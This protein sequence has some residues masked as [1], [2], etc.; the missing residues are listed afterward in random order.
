MSDGYETMS[1]GSVTFH[2]YRQDQPKAAIL[3]AP[4]MGAPQRYYR[5]F[6]DFLNTSGYAVISFDYLGIGES[7]TADITQITIKDWLQNVED[8]MD[9]VMK[10]YPSTTYYYICHSL[11]G[12]LFGLTKKAQNFKKMV[13]ITSQNGY[14]RY[15][16]NKWRYLIVWYVLFP[17]LTRVYGYFP[18][19]KVGL[20][21]DLPPNIALNWKKWCTSKDYFFSDPNLPET[22]NY[23]SYSGKILTIGFSDDS[24]ATLPAIKSLYE[25]YTSAEV[26]YNFYNPSEFNRKEIGHLGFFRNGSEDIWRIVIEWLETT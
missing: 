19:S 1:L 18:S 15:Y 13:A 5:H 2:H 20:G 10:N 8:A 3:L 4:A 6:A 16:Q 26:Q 17:V 22:E 11:G 7:L 21:E 12:Q 9:L 14:W 24:W 23:P 25:H